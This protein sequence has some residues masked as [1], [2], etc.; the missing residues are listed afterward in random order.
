[1]EHAT[2]IRGNAFERKTFPENQLVIPPY[3]CARP[4][5]YFA[6]GGKY[7]CNFPATISLQLFFLFF[8]EDADRQVAFRKLISSS[9]ETKRTSK[10]MKGAALAGNLKGLTIPLSVL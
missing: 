8:C 7:F 2:A 4:L 6:D 1:M 9:K 10:I 5:S 3:S